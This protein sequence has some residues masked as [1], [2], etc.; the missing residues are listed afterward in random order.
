MFSLLRVRV[1][2]V[3]PLL[4]R[5]M[6]PQNWANMLSGILLFNQK[7][8]TSS[9]VHFVPTVALDLQ[10]SSESRSS[11][12]PKSDRP[13]S[14]SAR[15]P[16]AT[17]N[18]KTFTLSRSLR[19]MPMPPSSSNSSTDWSAWGNNILASLMKMRSRTISCLCTSCWTV[20]WRWTW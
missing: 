11:P 19:V 17:S 20:G 16:S 13:S 12:M 2:G 6:W 15:P 5:P 7:G 14:H 9:F 1:C 3:G 10:T 8:R 4:S 18:T